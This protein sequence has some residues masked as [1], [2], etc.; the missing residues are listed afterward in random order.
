MGERPP[1]LYLRE[2]G[3]EIVAPLPTGPVPDD[4]AREYINPAPRE[5]PRHARTEAELRREVE[6]LREIEKW[7]TALHAGYF[8][9]GRGSDTEWLDAC[10]RR[11]LEGLFRAMAAAALAEEAHGGR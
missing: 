2:K 7:A 3:I 5:T 11:H 4:V 6:R 10:G 9:P 8:K 1:K